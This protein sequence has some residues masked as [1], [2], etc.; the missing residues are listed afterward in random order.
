MVNLALYWA[1]DYQR[2]NPDVRISVTGG[3][4]GTGITSLISNTVDIANASRAIKDEER[5]QA[6]VNGV[7]PVEY[8]VARDA[9]AVI[10][11]PQN[12]IQELTLQQVSDIYSGKFVKLAGIGW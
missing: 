12:P 1:E 10:V 2:E 4:S 3:G 9:I 5:E 11:N 6:L 8:V 7:E